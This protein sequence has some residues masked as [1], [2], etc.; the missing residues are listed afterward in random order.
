ML[1]ERGA[2]LTKCGQARD[3]HER[4]PVEVVG[5]DEDHVGDGRC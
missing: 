4:L 5:H 2:L 3:L 1:R